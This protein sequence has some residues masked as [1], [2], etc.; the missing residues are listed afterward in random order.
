MT[1]TPFIIYN[2]SNSNTVAAYRFSRAIRLIFV[3]VCIFSMFSCANKN[4]EPDIEKAKKQAVTFAEAFYNF[5]YK[6]AKSLCAEGSTAWL[7]LFVSN[8]KEEDVAAISKLEQAS[9]VRALDWTDSGDGLSED[10]AVTVTLKVENAFVI[11]SIGKPGRVV[12]SQ[13]LDIRMIEHNGQW[14]VRMEGLP[15]SEK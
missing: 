3:T 13:E 15:Q 9:T 4:S 11:D 7:D 5:D 14:L 2:M 1:T 12:P 8:I 10:T 6:K